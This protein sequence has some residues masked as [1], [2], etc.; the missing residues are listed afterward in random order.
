MNCIILAA[1]TGSRLFPLTKK[2][3]KCLLNLHDN[4]SIL[5]R[6]IGII[7]DVD[8]SIDIT[9]VV[10]FE[11]DQI[12]KK[13]DNVNFFANPFFR[14]TNSVASLW[15]AR[16]KLDSDVLIINSD[17]CFSRDVLQSI[18]SC[19]KDNFVV[20]DSSKKCT[21]AD[22][23][24]VVRDGTVSNMGKN[25]PF[26]NYFGEYAGITRLDSSGASLLGCEIERM[27]NIEEYDTWY[28]TALVHLV[29]E[30]KITLE[31]MDIQGQKWTEIDT[32]KDLSIAKKIFDD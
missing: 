12:Y 26:D 19:E 13:I 10:G 3:P 20:L 23:K 4:R 18:L 2:L 31:F 30:N 6:T 25:V 8:Q 9:V 15:F 7:R 29:Q 1:G 16:N 11:R 32:V 17:V 22:Y 21:D 27:L 24:V 28:E 14:V 5:E